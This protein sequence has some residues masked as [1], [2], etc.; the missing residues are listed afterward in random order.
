V[1]AGAG[2]SRVTVRLLAPTAH[3]AT[4]TGALIPAEDAEVTAELDAAAFAALRPA[5]GQ[6]LRVRIPR[7]A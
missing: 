5:A 7:G 4:A 6:E 1:A 2:R 3:D